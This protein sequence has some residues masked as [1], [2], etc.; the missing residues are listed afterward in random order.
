[1]HLAT[2]SACVRSSVCGASSLH[3][4]RTCYHSATHVGSFY[5]SPVRPLF[6][7]EQLHIRPRYPG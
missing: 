2:H 5:V 6:L 4:N 1:M 3:T 7:L